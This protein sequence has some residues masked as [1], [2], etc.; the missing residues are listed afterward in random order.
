MSAP[1][2]LISALALAGLMA[3]CAAP[4]PAPV[5]QAGAPGAQKSG[6]DKDEYVTGSR[7]KRSTHEQLINKT[8]A[9]GAREMDR[10]RPPEA[11]PRTN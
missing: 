4:T 3:A 2:R 10:N 11:G 6:D 9:A 8:G 7:L 5:V 1:T